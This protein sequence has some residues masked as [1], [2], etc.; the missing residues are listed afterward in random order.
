MIEQ[1]HAGP[2]SVV[3]PFAPYRIENN[4]REP[5]APLGLAE[6]G[7]RISEASASLNEVLSSELRKGPDS[8]LQGPWHQVSGFLAHSLQ[9]SWDEIRGYGPSQ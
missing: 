5:F 7:V 3:P 8:A 1:R 4:F 6:L 2:S 9:V